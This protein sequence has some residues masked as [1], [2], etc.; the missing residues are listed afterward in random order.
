MP[1]PVCGEE[2]GFPQPALRLDLGEGVSLQ[3]GHLRPL[4]QPHV[5]TRQQKPLS[6]PADCMLPAEESPASLPE[7]PE[8]G[9][10]PRVP[11]KV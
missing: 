9:R 3:G 1:S 6:L 5:E 2:G 4:P 8:W 7:D 11:L 10:D